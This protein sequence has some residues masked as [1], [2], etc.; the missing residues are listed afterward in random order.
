MDTHFSVSDI[1]DHTI[2][3]HWADYTLTTSLTHDPVYEWR[4]LTREPNGPQRAQQNPKSPMDPKRAQ[5]TP[6]NPTDPM[7]ANTGQFG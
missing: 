4:K 7:E 6:G 3:L 2:T 1:G 5:Q